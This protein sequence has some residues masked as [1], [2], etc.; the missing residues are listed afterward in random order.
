[1]CL[2]KCLPLLKITPVVLFLPSKSPTQSESTC[3]CNVAS[4]VCRAYVNTHLL[5]FTKYRPNLSSSCM[6]PL[7]G[8]LMCL[9]RHITA[10]AISTLSSTTYANFITKLR[11][12]VD[13]AH[14]SFS[15]ISIFAVCSSVLLTRGESTPFAPFNLMVSNAFSNK[16]RVSLQRHLIILQINLDCSIQDLQ[17]LRVTCRESNVLRLLHL[18][19]FFKDFSKD[20]QL[21]LS[22]NH[23]EVVTMT[24][25][26]ETSSQPQTKAGHVVP[27]FME[28]SFST[29]EH[30]FLQ[31][32]AG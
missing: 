4:D 26:F 32:D 30:V 2:D 19:P 8:S 17:L 6:C 31:I 28:L 15:E 25:S 22:C 7:R 18:R 13:S 16:F 5:F 3:T 1:M 23:T 27:T 20:L 14:V 21:L 10:S 24:Q 11:Y 9:V 12:E 29:S